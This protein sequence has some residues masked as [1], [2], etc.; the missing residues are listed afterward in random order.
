MSPAP[1]SEHQ[2]LSMILSGELRSFLKGKP[3]L[4]FAAPIDVLVPKPNASPSDH[5]SIDTVVQPDLLVVCERSKVI[6]RGILGMPD[7]IMEIV[8]PSSVLRDLNVKKDLYARYGCR[9]YW[10]W[11]VR[12]Q[13]VSRL[14]R[15]ENGQWDEGTTYEGAQVAESM[16]LPGLRL[17]LA[18]L[19]EEMG[20][21]D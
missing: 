12:L 7:V 8:S 18:E 13:W 6:P 4:P 11:D 2:R 14:V 20:I 10:I 17:A 16:V 3:C 15:Q 5:G 21:K 9:E 1:S 19:R